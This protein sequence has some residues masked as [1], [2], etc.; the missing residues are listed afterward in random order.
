MAQKELRKV[1]KTVF[2]GAVLALCLLGA[3]GN[4]WAE[5]GRSASAGSTPS[6]QSAVMVG[7]KPMH[8]SANRSIR[9]IK[10]NRLE[11]FGNVYVRRPSELLTADYAVLDLDTERIVAEGNAAYF[12]P[13]TVIYGS[14]M[15]FNYILGT[16]TI[17]NGRVESEHYQLT[18]DWLERLGEDQFLAKNAD[19]STCKDC[20]NSWKI[21]GK[22]IHLTIEGYARISNMLIKIND[23]PVLYFPYLIMPVKTERQ[24]GFLFPKFRLGTVH[25]FQ[26]IQPFFWALSRSQDLTMA[27]GR[28]TAR[29]WKGELQHR[30]SLAGRS[31]G[32]TDAFLLQ[33]RTFIDPYQRRIALH[34]FHNLVLPFSTELKLR[35]LDTS[36]RDYARFF[37]DDVPGVNE[38]AL[39]SEA[40]LSR[41]TRNLSVYADA[42]RIKKLLRNNL[43]GFDH[44]QVQEVP[45]VGVSTIDHQIT[46]WI[47]LYW[48]FNL[49]YNHFWRDANAFDNLPGLTDPSGLFVPGRD[50]LR[51]GQRVMWTPELYYT[52]RLGSYLDFMPGV[53]YRGFY[54]SFDQKDVPDTRRGFLVADARLGTNMERVYGGTVKHRMRP[55]F[56]YSAIPFIQQDKNHPF[57]RQL[58]FGTGNQ[59]VG[60]NGR[61][62]DDFDIVP[63]SFNA[64]QYFTPIGN[65]LTMELSNSFIMKDYGAQANSLIPESRRGEKG[66]VLSPASDV[67]S[68]RKVVDV[69]MGQ[70]I[71]FIEF[72]KSDRDDERPLSR[73]FLLSRTSLAQLQN[74]TELYY[75]PYSRA[76]QF[77]SGISYVFARFR[78]RLQSFERTVSLAY[79]RNKV[80]TPSPGAENITG[81]FSFSINDY[82]SIGMSNTM[83]LI[84]KRTTATTGTVVWQSPSECYQVSIN[85]S[86]RVDRG[87]E[88]TPN[89]VLNLNGMGYTNVMDPNSAGSIAT[90]R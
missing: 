73:A 17:E 29:G 32:Q 20:P 22:T 85:I 82:F 67:P 90:K 23:T 41:T 74:T 39:V 87:V 89:L 2:T 12:T 15:D 62:F 25:G 10:R 3:S 81:S 11:L 79:S 7:G 1:L 8:V 78:K 31:Y 14:K 69:T 68:Y 35:W 56:T 65:S 80:T 72:R 88:F 83:D 19:Y 38:P 34:S 13:E 26:Y 42:K 53:R 61:Q 86:K 58:D 9:D 57:S 71:N 77:S 33:D 55:S 49:Q 27:F 30:Y 60:Q 5:K 45:V 54:Y 50:P 59:F 44:Q 21:H 52:A 28:L 36:D 46:K 51:R 18:G 24:S 63:V 6:S 16:G 47:P 66:V 70:T 43:T 40:S 76:F 75:Y 48:G 64:P 4:A 37:P 84:T